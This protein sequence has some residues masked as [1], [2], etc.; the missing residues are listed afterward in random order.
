MAKQKAPVEL[1]GG[2]GFNFEDLI[3]ARFLLDMLAGANSLGAEY[4]R[5]TRLDWQARPTFRIREPRK[6]TF[7]LKCPV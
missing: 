1:T 3:A 2:T 5:V 7:A 6:L 4:G